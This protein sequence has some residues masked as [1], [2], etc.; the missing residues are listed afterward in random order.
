MDPSARRFPQKV[1]QLSGFYYLHI[2]YRTTLLSEA[3]PQGSGYLF[4]GKD[5]IG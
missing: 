1:I 4:L 5:V 2:L 3:P